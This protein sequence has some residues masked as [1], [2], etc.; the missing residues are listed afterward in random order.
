MSNRSFVDSSYSHL[1]YAKTKP[2]KKFSKEGYHQ[3][4]NIDIAC[5]SKEN[6]SDLGT[7]TSFNT[8]RK[9]HFPL[10]NLHSPP[11][12]LHKAKDASNNNIYNVLKGIHKR[13]NEEYEI[14]KTFRTRNKH[15]AQPK[16]TKTVN[17]TYAKRRIK[18]SSRIARC[19]NLQIKNGMPAIKS[20]EK[21][22][23]LFEK[24][25]NKEEECKDFED[26]QSIVENDCENDYS[27]LYSSFLSP[28]S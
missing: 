18:V 5:V 21:Q 14:K 28:P 20:N 12:N 4:L 9:I 2:S 8:K 19:L 1:L 15:Q 11:P 25:G 10:V 27:F 13:L 7:S 22:N 24:I 6:A 23:S 16:Q 3:L 26:S 17:D